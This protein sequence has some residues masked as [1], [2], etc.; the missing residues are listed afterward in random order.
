MSNPVN[1]TPGQRTLLVAQHAEALRANLAAALEHYQRLADIAK[2]KLAA[3]R[4]ASVPDLTRLHDEELAALRP[5]LAN[6]QERPAIL[7]QLAQTLLQPHLAHARLSVVIAQLPPQ[8]RPALTALTAGLKAA[9]E[10]LQR[11]NKLVSDV[12]HGLQGVIRGV[13]AEVSRLSQSRVAYTR[14]GRHETRVEQ[15]WIEAVG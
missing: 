5:M 11:R 2:R 15:K 12:A 13:F 8:M 14:D 3:L 9:G 7:A 1:R 4:T 10:E 6:E